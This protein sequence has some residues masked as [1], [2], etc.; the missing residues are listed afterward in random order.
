MSTPDTVST[1]MTPDELE[2]LA[3]LFG[4][5]S[6]ISE[7]MIGRIAGREFFAG[8]IADQHGEVVIN[9]AVKAHLAR[10][11]VSWPKF[12]DKL[13]TLA[14]LHTFNDPKKAS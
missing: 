11:Q 9:I 5:A 6:G 3:R 12:S 4:L 8:L 10:V 7:A 14:E 2:V 13:E 1:P